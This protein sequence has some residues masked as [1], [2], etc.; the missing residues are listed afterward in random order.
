MQAVNYVEKNGWEVVSFQT[1]HTDSGSYTKFIYL[2]FFE[3]VLRLPLFSAGSPHFI[4]ILPFP[5]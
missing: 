4:P 5:A 2:L 1:T 3:S